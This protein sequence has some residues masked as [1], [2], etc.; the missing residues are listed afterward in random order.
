MVKAIVSKEEFGSVDKAWQGEYVP[1][2]D[3]SYVLRV[4]PVNGVSLGRIESAVKALDVER[5]AREKAEKAVADYI[6]EQ[7][8]PLDPVKARGALQKMAQMKDWKPEDKVREQI[9]HLKTEMGEAF[10][11]EKKALQ[12]KIELL[13]RGLNE[14]VVDAALM[15]GIAETKANP[16]LAD[17]LRARIRPELDPASKKFVPRVL[18][19]QGN[20]RYE[21][22]GTEMKPM[23]VAGFIKSLEKD[24]RYEPFFPGTGSSGTGT[25]SPGR[26]SG[27]PQQFTISRAEASGPQGTQR[28]Q[29]LRAEAAKVGQTV[30]VTE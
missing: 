28:Y 6:D 7:G 27:R 29:Q 20:P 16:L 4:E 25:T 13:E 10:G 12:D 21:L 9:E 3:G 19:E 14:S 24:K 30:T 5:K 1:Q 22:Q 26:S 8:T 17:L 15:N 23:S 2:E 11:K 18:D